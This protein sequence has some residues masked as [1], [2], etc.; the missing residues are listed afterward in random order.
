MY[1]LDE[2]HRAMVRGAPPLGVY[3]DISRFDMLL[4]RSSFRWTYADMARM[5]GVS[6]RHVM[7][8]EKGRTEIPLTVAWTLHHWLSGYRRL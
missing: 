8:M 3:P 5:L 6:A 1:D 7:R 2:R 4:A